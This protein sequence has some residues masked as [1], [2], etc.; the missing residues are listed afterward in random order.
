MG[1]LAKLYPS[2]GLAI[3]YC[4]PN[5]VSVNTLQDGTAAA[6]AAAA[7]AA[8]ACWA[9]VC[10]QDSLNT[11]QRKRAAI[12]VITARRI[13]SA[14]SHCCSPIRVQQQQQQQQRRRQRQQHS[15]S[16]TDVLHVWR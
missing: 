2:F 15:H 10:K 8:A 11:M 7:A 4:V 12:A 1:R 16:V 14:L 13:T 9:A 6:T 3:Q 5:H